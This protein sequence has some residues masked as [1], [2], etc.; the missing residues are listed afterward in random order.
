MNRAIP[1]EFN[2]VTMFSSFT[3]FHLD[4]ISWLLPYSIR[5][6]IQNLLLLKF[7][8]AYQDYSAKY[9]FLLLYKI[10][11][12]VPFI[13]TGAEGW[14]EKEICTK[15]VCDRPKEG[16]GR[17]WAVEIMPVQV[18]YSFGKLPLP[19]ECGQREFFFQR[20]SFLLQSFKCC[21]IC[22]FENFDYHSPLA[23]P[24]KTTARC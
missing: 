3:F 20:E 22:E 11:I 4:Y 10:E 8:T 15:G 16:E 23:W 13:S 14:G 2:P 18:C 9:K 17:R 24:D 6:T 7:S 21:F 1:V 19:T 5:S 12:S